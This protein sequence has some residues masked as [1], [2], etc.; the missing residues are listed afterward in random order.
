MFGMRESGF[1]MKQAGCRMRIRGKGCREQLVSIAYLKGAEV[2]FK[3][4][5][6]KYRVQDSSWYGKWCNFRHAD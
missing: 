2:I 6:S 1:K 4:F 3:S 5:L